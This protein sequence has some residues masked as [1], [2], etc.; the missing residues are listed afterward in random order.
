MRRKLIIGIAACI[1]AALLISGCKVGSTDRAAKEAELAYKIKEA[2]EK[3]GTTVEIVTDGSEEDINETAGQPEKPEETAP[4]FELNADLKDL[5]EFGKSMNFIVGK[6]NPPKDVVTVVNL[7]SLFMKY[8]L[9]TGDALL[10][11]EI[12]GY[13]NK[14]YFVIGSPCGNAVAAKLLKKYVDD[15]GGCHIFNEGEAWIRLIPTSKETFAV[16]VGGDNSNETEKAAM[17]L[18]NFNYYAVHGDLVRIGGT[19]ENPSIQ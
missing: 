4:G 12:T 11:T 2:L 19:A 10:D 17:V 9:E 16:Y 15:K 7:K 18:G 1:I 6:N 13:A 8:E 5:D 3:N 14:N